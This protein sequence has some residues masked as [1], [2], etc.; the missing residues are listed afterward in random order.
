M[1]ETTNRENKISIFPTVNF[2]KGVTSQGS[3]TNAIKMFDSIGANTFSSVVGT[4]MEDISE[5]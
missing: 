3:S 4:D 5:S 2:S 1:I